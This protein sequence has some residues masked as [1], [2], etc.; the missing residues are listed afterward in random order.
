MKF[1][2]IKTSRNNRIFCDSII[3]Y[4]AIEILLSG[5][6]DENTEIS[7]YSK[8][9]FEHAIG[10]HGGF[11]FIKI[12]EKLNN[13]EII[14]LKKIVAKGYEKNLKTIFELNNY[15][16]EKLEINEDYLHCL[17][18]PN[19]LE[20]TFEIAK[21]KEIYAHHRNTR[22]QFLPPNSR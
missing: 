19:S 8:F 15:L 13:K 3:R 14:E 11:N 6:F 5:I 9:N 20:Y 2:F 17:N 18:Y 12:S 1:N 10:K 22:N 21:K 4:I 16:T 7:S